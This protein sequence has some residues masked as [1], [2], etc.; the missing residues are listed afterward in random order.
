MR[1]TQKIAKY[2]QKTPNIIILS[3]NIDFLVCFRS[4]LTLLG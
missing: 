4:I 3:L 1:K 2:E